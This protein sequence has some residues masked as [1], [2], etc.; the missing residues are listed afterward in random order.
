[1]RKLSIT[2]SLIL[3]CLGVLAKPAKPGFI[4]YTQPDGTTIQIMRHGDEWA[5]WTT[6]SRGQVVKKDADGFF[7][8][9]RGMT[10]AR[11]ARLASVR[12]RAFRET[13]ASAPS[14]TP[15]ALGQKH[16]LVILAEFS[17]LN[18]TIEAPRQSIS[19][20]LNQ[21]GY[22]LHGA[23]GSA[24][25]YYYDNSH[26]LFEPVF[27]V[28]GPVKLEKGKAY[29]GQNE[30]DDEEPNAAEAIRDACVLADSEVDFS[31]YDLDGDGE[32]DLVYVVYAG[33]GE[34][35]SDDDDAIWPHQWYLS[36]AGLPLTQDGKRI[37]R[38]ACGSELMG[39]GEMD[40]IGTICHEF[41]HAIGLPD[42]YD[43][44]Y[45]TNGEAAGLFYFSLMCSG[46]YV[47]DGW[48]PPY[49]NIVE[50]TLLGWVDESALQLFP[51]DG[52]YTLTSVDDNRAYKTLTDTEGEFFVYECRDTHGWDRHVP[53]SGLLVYHVDQ[54]S[55]KVS[56]ISDDTPREVSASFLWK[57]WDVY[58]AI[59]ENGSH[60]CF[61]IVPAA[62]QSNLRYG[63]EYYEGY[64][65]YYNR[66]KDRYIP[67]P[68]RKKVTSYVP[69]SWNG[70]IGDAALSEI[71]YA[72]GQ[73]TFRVS[74]M[75]ANVLDYPVIKN[76]GKGNYA[77]G[78]VFA[79]E[80]SVPDGYG[81]EGVRWFLDGSQV[82][83]PSL[84]LT[85]GSHVIEAEISRP[86]GEK[87]IITLEI[88][89]K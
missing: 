66:N 87:D 53:A 54:S 40:S 4:Y 56:I 50:R 63:Y 27:D 41:G 35:D 46:S 9:V 75:D 16:F 8:E 38:Y 5:S 74:G 85:S 70:V 65:Y 32:V 79:L 6:N 28:V 44:D 3:C 49:L 52:V 45:D 48:T 20:M 37:D 33:F 47:N 14:R 39:N 61:Y 80:L 26:G 24:R 18:F 81:A 34:A 76:P 67:F 84:T 19:D 57:Y 55:R 69:V 15:V 13:K 82:S 17:D 68:G 10:P 58:N 60:P 2:F 42:F 43:T 89:V 11:A 62:D 88:K 25:D 71:A 21:N 86:S 29:Y 31:Q 73:S 36:A 59:N 12:R 23:T 7:R 78:S 83:G 64:G 77:V 22:S 30:E 72:D 1:M 51:H